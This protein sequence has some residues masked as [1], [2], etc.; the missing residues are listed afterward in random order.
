MVRI[1]VVKHKA[2]GKKIR[3]G[4]ESLTRQRGY[5]EYSYESKIVPLI[6]Q[7]GYG[8]YS[9]GSKIKTRPLFYRQRGRGIGSIFRTFLRMAKPLIYSGLQTVKPLAKTVGKYAIKEGIRTVSDIADD[10]IQGENLKKSLKQR[11]KDAGER[12]IKNAANHTW[13]KFVN[14]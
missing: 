8:E 2:N 3:R 7:R 14:Q 12:V 1:K 4:K 5:G 9:Y 10:V 6:R 13:N 11:S